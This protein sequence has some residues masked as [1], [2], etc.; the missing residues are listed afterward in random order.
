MRFDR[1]QALR[2][3]REA[4]EIYV[5]KGKRVTHLDMKKER[6]DDE[7]LAHLIL[8]PTGNLRSPTLR[9]GSTLLVGF[10]AETYRAVFEKGR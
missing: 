4:A 3:A 1:A 8:G 5:A 9:K 7:T 10:D 6:P 2:L